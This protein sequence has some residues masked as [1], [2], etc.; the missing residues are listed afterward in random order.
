MNNTEYRIVTKH[1]RMGFEVFH[2]CNLLQLTESQ[3]SEL[4]KSL[5]EHGVIVIRN[6]NL[7]AP[8]LKEFA[9]KT[10]NDS[11]LGNRHKPIKEEI[12][13]HLQSPGVSILGNPEG[14]NTKVAGQS[15]WQWHHDKDHLPASEGLD[16]NSLYVI[17]LYGVKIPPEGLDGQVHTTQFIDMIQAYENLSV[18]ER[19]QLETCSM[20]HLPPI[21]TQPIQEVPRKLHPIVST[22]KV[23]GKKGLYL[24]SDTSILKGMENK[25]EEAKQFWQQLFETIL[26]VAPIYA[27][28]WNPGDIVF[29]DNSQVMH[30]GLPYDNTKYQRIA[31]RVPVMANSI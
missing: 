21:I 25:L 15:A 4:K 31:L 14:L 3:I 22:H 26:K 1:P 27:H 7:T 13:L 29:W 6:Q 9:K 10:F 2:N 19:Q 24:G 20:Y 30:A 16:M 23:T 12:P 8:E 18:E 17:M 5:W 11:T 28:V